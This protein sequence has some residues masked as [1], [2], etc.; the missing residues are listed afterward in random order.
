MRGIA[1][2]LREARGAF[3]GELAHASMAFESRF[4]SFLAH[5]VIELRRERVEVRDRWRRWHAVVVRI[6]FVADEIEV[7]SAIRMFLRARQRLLRNG[8]DGDAGR[9]R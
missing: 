1:G 7:R 2:D 8:S 5:D 4:E 9:K 3:C 6:F